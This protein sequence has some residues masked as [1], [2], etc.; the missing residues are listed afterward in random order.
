M[1]EHQVPLLPGKNTEA[2]LCFRVVADLSERSF[3]QAPTASKARR[4]RRFRAAF[5]SGIRCVQ[6]GPPGLVPEEHTLGSMSDTASDSTSETGCGEL[7]GLGSLLESGGT[8]AVCS[9]S[10]GQVSVKP[11]QPVALECP[12]PWTHGVWPVQPGDLGTS[13]DRT[14]GSIENPVLPDLGTTTDRTHG[15]N[16]NPVQPGDLGTP[17]DR[18]H[19]AWPVQ[20]GDL[21]TPTSGTHGKC[22]GA[23]ACPNSPAPEVLTNGSKSDAASNVRGT[24]EATG[25]SPAD[26]HTL[27]T[28][29]QVRHA[30]HTLVT[31]Q[32]Q[33][34]QSCLQANAFSSELMADAQQDEFAVNPLD[35]VYEIVTSV[36]AGM[37]EVGISVVIKKSS[38]VGLPREAV[39]EALK[40]WEHLSVMSINRDHCTVKLLC[41]IDVDRLE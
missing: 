23:P 36:C 27:V 5:L 31:E 34:D 8:A 6:L 40:I 29:A 14:H 17:T 9:Q 16:E 25:S 22:N 32:R 15:S 20:P 19:G 11:V 41:V 35:A 13:T 7:A 39:I 30:D 4:D 21:G 33:S 18:T 3:V 28:K 38:L 10:I 37:E 12:T 2:H 1:A 24:S 26:D